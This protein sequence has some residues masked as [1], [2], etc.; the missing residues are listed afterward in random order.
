VSL[1]RT[2]LTVACATLSV[3][4]VSSTAP[5]SAVA[6]PTSACSVTGDF[7]RKYAELG[8]TGSVLGDCVRD[9]GPVNKGGVAQPF[10]SG[11]LYWNPTTGSHALHGAIR[12]QYAALAWENSYLGFP[13]TDEFEVR[14][15]RGQHFQGGSIYWSPATGARDVTGAIR[16]KWAT[17][18]WENSYLGFP[19]T[20]EIPL[21]RSGGRVQH[22]SGGSAYWTPATGAH[23]V[24]GAIQGTW[25]ATGYEWGNLGYPTTD[26]YDVPGGK[27]SDFQFGSITWDAPTGRTNVTTLPRIAVLGD[28]ITYGAC[29]G[30]AQA[31]PSSVPAVA[32]ACFGW[33]GATSD[34]M[35]AFVQNQGF[36]SAWPNMYAPV[37]TVDL[38][39]AIAESDVVVIGLGTNDA[40][41]DRQPFPART[42]PAGDT[43]PVPSGHVPVGNGYFDQKID[44]FMGLAAGKPVYW[45][46]VGFNGT[47]PSTNDFFRYRDERLAAATGR[48]PNLHVLNWSGV[49]KAHPEFLLDEVH[50]NEAGRGARW[51]L[52]TAAAWGR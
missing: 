8:S 26:E 9:E 46:D 11:S 27:R 21:V 34:E 13:T 24:R 49:V 2:V 17:L 39:R 30:T 33:P 22:F 48:W 52:L 47:N 5:A 50:P 3:L 15:G 20:S 42:W 51:A 32:T 25:A 43:A 16:E 18:G 12:G 7:A 36:H 19:T 28:S 6:G 14:G 41:R 10:R 1:R 45:Y 29:G 35:Q 38:R 44:Y 31:L 37:P 23:V 40:L 4:A